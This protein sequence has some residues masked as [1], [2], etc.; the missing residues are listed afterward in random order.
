MKKHV[1][2]THVGTFDESEVVPLYRARIGGPSLLYS[3]RN[4]QV[5]YNKDTY[6]DCVYYRKFGTHIGTRTCLREGFLL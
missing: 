6:P 4:E 3:F 2:R 1:T 5:C